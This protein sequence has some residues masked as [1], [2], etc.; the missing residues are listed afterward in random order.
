MLIISSLIVSCEIPSTNQ[1]S[2][3][4]MFELSTQ[5]LSLL[6]S[7]KKLKDLCKSISTLEAIISPEWGDR[8]YSYNNQWSETEEVFELRDGQ[9]DQMLILFDY[10]GVIINGFAHESIMNKWKGV[11]EQVPKEFQEF[12]YEEP[13]K[14]IGTTFCIWKMNSDEKWQIGDIEFPEDNYLDGSAE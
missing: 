5:N 12:I 3:D 7:S 13:V 6:P 9:G 11:I 8:Y 4:T 10:K 1:A 2:N 14:S